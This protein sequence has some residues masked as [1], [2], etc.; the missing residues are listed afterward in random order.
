MATVRRSRKSRTGKAG[1][2]KGRRFLVLLPQGKINQRVQAVGPQ[3]FGIVS[4]D[5]AKQR[6]K[7][8]LCD[9]YGEV[10]IEPTYFAHKHNDLRLLFERIRQVAREHDLRDLVVAIERTGT[11]HVPVYHAFRREGFDTRLVHPLTS[12]QFRQPADPDNKTDDTDLAGIFRATANGFGLIEHDWSD[13][14]QQLQLL[15]RQRRELVH[16]TT[17]LRCQIRE[18]L[19][20]LMPGYAECFGTHFFD[21]PVP[22]L[23]ARGTGS[24]QAITA[25]GLLGLRQLI[26]GTVTYRQVTLLHA[27]DWAPTAPPCHRQEQLLR[28]NLDCLDD[29]RLV[30]IKQI[31]ALEQRSAQVLAGTPYVLLL[32]LPGI[33]VISAADLA[34]EMGPPPHYATANHITGRAGL[35]PSRYQSDRVDCANGPL[36]RRGNRRLRAALMR[37]ADNLLHHNHHYQTLAERFTLQGKDPRWQHVK[38]AK[39]FT[40]LAFVLLAGAGR[41]PHPACQPRDSIFE[42]LLAFHHQHRT[43][44]QVTLAD[45]ER[46]NAQLS[47]RARGDEA[48][49]L[50]KLLDD[51]AAHRRHGLV[52]LSQIIPLVL[53]KLGVQALQSKPEGRNPS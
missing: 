49:H 2:G 33:N 37:I 1:A 12:K 53:A 11:Y 8:L 31:Q 39:A 14:Y 28:A 34:G 3:H 26:P 20:Q 25:A 15:A 17:I 52:E 5:C 35:V 16:K 21:S 51:R 36:R 50:Q 18:V 9:F 44:I 4:V 10:L 42:K 47:R 27:L 38:V 13:D 19:H 40:R 45:F 22:M 43:D 7:L 32:A 24:A 29:D 41:V 46:I 48:N 30:K 6:S 23:L